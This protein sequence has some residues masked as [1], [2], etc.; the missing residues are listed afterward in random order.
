M[1][2]SGSRAPSLPPFGYRLGIPL[3]EDT[4]PV[5][6][7]FSFT[8]DSVTLVLFTFCSS[9]LEASESGELVSLKEEAGRRKW[10]VNSGTLA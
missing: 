6:P 9:G 10:D 4:F 5:A 7:I 1:P 8:N 3:L 2:T